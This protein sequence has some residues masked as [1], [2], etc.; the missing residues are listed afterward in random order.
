MGQ[1]QSEAI[2]QQAATHYQQRNFDLALNLLLQLNA[3]HPNSPRI[4][5]PLTRCLMHLERLPEALPYAEQL[6]NLDHP[7]APKL[8]EQLQ[9][10]FEVGGVD[11]TAMPTAADL[12]M[13]DIPDNTALESLDMST[14]ESSFNRP[15]AYH[16]EREI[17]WGPIIKV[18]VA[19]L[20]M[21]LML[22][23]I[24]LIEGDS[25]IKPVEVPDADGSPNLSGGYLVLLLVG[26]GFLAFVLTG[27]EIFVALLVLGK[28][29]HDTFFDN[30]IDVTGNALIVFFIG[31]I[32]VVGW[33][34]ALRYLGNYYELN[35]IQLIL[36]VIVYIFIGIVISGIISAIFGSIA[37]L[38]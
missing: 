17:N 9:G 34:F 29:K 28:L 37:V 8:I 6:L 20:V 15:A 33:I 36:F 1:E 2:F 31:L 13:D 11:D 25:G 3:S 22:L 23:P 19:I 18:G 26:F 14:E 38:A 27:F 4:L 5:Y 12:M 7:K 30:M 32:P 24:F 16:G 21:I 35:I 10:A